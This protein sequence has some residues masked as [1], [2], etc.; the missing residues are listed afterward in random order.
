MMA[1]ATLAY[2]DNNERRLQWLIEHWKADSEPIVGFGLGA[3][4]SRTNR[5]LAWVRYRIREMQ[6]SIGQLHSSPVARI[7]EQHNRG[8]MAGRNLILEMRREIQAELKEAVE[9]MGRLQA[10]ID[11]LDPALQESV[12]I[13]CRG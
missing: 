5:Q 10:A 7:M 11:D 4:W 1:E 13:A 8:R 3:S 9:E 12:R 6:Y 2:R